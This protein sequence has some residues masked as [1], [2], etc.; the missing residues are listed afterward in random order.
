VANL[1]NLLSTSLVQSLGLRDVL[2]QRER[3]TQQLV[4]A[5]GLQGELAA[6]QELG[7]ARRKR[8]TFETIGTL[9]GA[10]GGF[11]A[12]GP[13]GGIKGASIGA[14]LGQAGG[15]ILSGKVAQPG[16]GST[17]ELIQAGVGLAGQFAEQKAASKV[18]EAARERQ[19]KQDLLAARK[20]ESDISLTQAKTAQTAAQTKS[21]L[22]KKPKKSELPPKQ[23]NLAQQARRGFDIAEKEVKNLLENPEEVTKQLAQAEFGGRLAS[24]T[25]KK[26][27]AA[28][29]NA[30]DGVIRFRTGAV[31]SNEEMKLYMD[32][33]GPMAGDTPDVIRFKMNQL[34]DMIKIM[35]GESVEDVAAA[36]A[37][38]STIE[39][40][41]EKVKGS[42]VMKFDATGKRI[43]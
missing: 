15:G 7:K 5:R 14:K 23:K 22:T 33:F 26:I 28:V 39:D 3:E 38:F 1:Q 37:A 8:G 34:N 9:V 12:G 36:E 2:N 41:T 24:P 17:S 4:Q 6:Q 32:T 25:A 20:T 29:S 21:L 13:G 19:A 30:L 42:T 35:N 31:I 16:T 18:A 40:I 11:L 43:Q 10:A 27:R